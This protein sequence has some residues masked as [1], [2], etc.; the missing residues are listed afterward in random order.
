L[1]YFVNIN[2]KLSVFSLVRGKVTSPRETRDVGLAHLDIVNCLS[3]IYDSDGR[4]NI[5][6]SL[7]TSRA[8]KIE[9]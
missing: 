6:L 5:M 7:T 4:T 9:N 1:L 8:K 2:N 3:V